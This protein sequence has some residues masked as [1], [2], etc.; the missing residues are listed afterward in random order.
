MV[1]SSIQLTPKRPRGGGAGCSVHVAGC[2]ASQST[3]KS[4]VSGEPQAQST[5]SL[6]MIVLIQHSKSSQL[7]EGCPNAEKESKTPFTLF[8]L[9]GWSGKV[10]PALW[11]NFPTSLKTIKAIKLRFPSQVTLNLESRYHEQNILIF[12]NST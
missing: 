5:L 12:L 8:F 6:E 1:S 10:R 9:V 3:L 7:Q 4:R 11:V 2:P